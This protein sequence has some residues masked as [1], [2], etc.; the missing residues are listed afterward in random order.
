ML[1]TPVVL[2]RAPR[3]TPALIG[4]GAVSLVLGPGVL[5]LGLVLISGEQRMLIP[6]VLAVLLLVGSCAL[7]WVVGR[8]LLE[9]TASGVTV[10]NG[11]IARRCDWADV[12]RIDVDRR[13]RTCGRVIVRLV[14]GESLP[15]LAS[16]PR[17]SILRGEGVPSLDPER[18]IPYLR[19]VDAH[20]RWLA[21]RTAPGRV[22]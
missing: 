20:R 4:I 14:D 22:D 19:T 1:E 11:A 12:A 3:V 6:L 7:L 13:R 8:P 17:W 15:V 21:T 16:D 18:S 10:R 5:L 9:V 2:Y